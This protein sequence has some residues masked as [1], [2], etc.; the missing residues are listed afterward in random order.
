MSHAIGIS[1]SV[2][3]S[4]PS[5]YT[6]LFLDYIEH[7][8]IGEF[9]DEEAFQSFLEA[10]E[11]RKMTFGLHSPLY[12]NQ[13]KYDLLE[14]VHYDPER[15][16]KQFE[17][18]VKRMAE[19]NAAYILVHFPYFK[20]QGEGSYFKQIK[21]GLEKLATL[22]EKYNLPIICEPKL[23]FNR[24]SVGIEALHQF[25]FE[26]WRKY[27][28]KLC[29]DIGDYLM[30]V[31]DRALHYISKWREFIKVVH[32]HNVEFH[33]YKYI[34]AP[35]HPSHEEDDTHFKVR[36]I[37]TTLIASKGIFFVFEHTPHSKPTKRFVEEGIEWVRNL[38][39]QESS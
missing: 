25:P 10:K 2:I 34:W 37:I 11:S 32:L 31:G 4:D 14:K 21:A 13:S 1:G 24:S 3:M 17:E 38:I 8:E 19:L 36:E 35:V 5:K 18:E 28:V 12:R 6:E 20:E 7:I 27:N 26:E 29:I 33:A 9:Q 23:G 30:A 22:Q 15:A 39:K 16:W